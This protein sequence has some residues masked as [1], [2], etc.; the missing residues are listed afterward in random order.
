MK[1]FNIIND[2]SIVKEEME[3]GDIYTEKNL[4]GEVVNRYLLHPPEAKGCSIPLHLKMSEF[5]SIYLPVIN[6]GTK[7]PVLRDEL[8]SLKTEELVVDIKLVTKDIL[9]NPNLILLAD[10]SVSGLYVDSLA[11]RKEKFKKVIL[12][13]KGKVNWNDIV[14]DW[15]DLTD[16]LRIII[17]ENQL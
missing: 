7:D 17:G 9:N 15:K 6:Y 10:E 11:G 8:M 3:I 2:N 13:C 1:T 16:N 5:K 12:Y 4:H 14:Y